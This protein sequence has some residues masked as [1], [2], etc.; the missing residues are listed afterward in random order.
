MAQQVCNGAMLQCSFGV[1]PSTMIVI[2]KAMVNTSKQPA[3][4]IMD[5]V[6]IANIPPFGMCSAPTNPAVIA[7]TS[8]AAGVFTP[9]P[10]IPVTT[11]PWAPGCPTVTLGK[12]PAL[13]S[14]SKLMCTW[15]GVISVTQPGQ[16]THNI[17]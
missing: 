4:T 8:A 17:P 13:N 5:N 15:L 9:A 14:T 12:I 16:F 2:P 11:A 10:C 7:A 3:A 1:A 6:P